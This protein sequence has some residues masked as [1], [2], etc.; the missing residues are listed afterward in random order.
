MTIQETITTEFSGKTTYFLSDE[1]EM[2]TNIPDEMAE[3]YEKWL[4][5]KKVKWQS[6]MNPKITFQC[7]VKDLGNMGYKVQS[8]YEFGSF[9]ETLY[10]KLCKD[11]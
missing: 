4:E 7:S 6:N 8:V 1:V 2:T 11:K 5:S 9:G 3:Q 10:W